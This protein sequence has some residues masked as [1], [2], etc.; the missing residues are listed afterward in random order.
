MTEGS[1]L[2]IKSKTSS[3]TAYTL[4]GYRPALQEIAPFSRNV[5]YAGNDNSL[6]E[7]GRKDY[8]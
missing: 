6:R 4:R 8:T 1:N 2:F 3:N 5:V 7:V